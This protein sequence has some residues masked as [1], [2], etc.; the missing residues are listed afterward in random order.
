MVVFHAMSNVSYTLFPDNGSH[1]DPAVTA[2]VIGTVAVG[3]GTAALMALKRPCGV[4]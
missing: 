4:D 3:I 1:Y 2:V